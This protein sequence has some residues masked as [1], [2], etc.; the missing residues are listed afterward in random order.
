[1]TVDQEERFAKYAT[2]QAEIADLAPSLF[3]YDQLEK[4]AVATYVDWRPEENSPVM[5]YQIYAAF[6]GVN[7]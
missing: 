5:G 2:L 4:H 7:N 6:I 1:P 3:L